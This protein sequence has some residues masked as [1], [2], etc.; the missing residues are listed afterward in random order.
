MGSKT[1]QP[2]LSLYKQRK[3]MQRLR[4][5]LSAVTTSAAAEGTCLWVRFIKPAARKLGIEF[6]NWQSLR[7]SYA[8]WL[9]KAGANQRC[10]GAALSRGIFT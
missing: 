6:V 1:A 2:N 4:S 5:L 10:A 8:T 7:T 9:I 3:Q